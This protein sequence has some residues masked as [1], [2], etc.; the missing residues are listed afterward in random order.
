[1]TIPLP[2]ML[3]PATVLLLDEEE[4]LR[5]RGMRLWVTL[6]RS[7]R[8]ARPALVALLGRAAAPL[9]QL[10]DCA[11]MCWPEPFTTF[12]PCAA[13]LSPDE[14]TVL[15]LL[16]QADGD[17]RDRAELLL[18]DLLPATD[19]ERLWAAACRLVA[20]RAGAC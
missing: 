18:C 1:M 13:R 15:A 17:S 6:A 20:D 16:R 10:M 12:P 7:G 19:R 5:L 8:N 3:A 11:V 4:R 2:F 9:C 14:A